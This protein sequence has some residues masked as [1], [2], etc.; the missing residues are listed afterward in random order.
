MAD[1]WAEGSQD[2]HIPHYNL[3]SEQST[4]GSMMLERS[5]LE[6]ARGIVEEADFYRPNHQEIYNALVKLHERDEPVD[7][8][9]LQEEL[10][11]RG[12]LDDCGGTEYLM[13]LVESVATA[14]HV[15]YYAK[16]V[17]KKSTLRL[18][19][20][21]N[22]EHK[23][24]CASPDADP[25]Q[26][27]SWM[28]GKLEELAARDKEEE[29]PWKTLED[30]LCGEVKPVEWIVRGLIPR[31][32]ISMIT[33]DP[34]SMKSWATIA[35]AY[36]VANG[37]PFLGKYTTTKCSVLMHDIENGEQET[38]RRMKR[39]ATG[40]I[41]EGFEF[42]SNA[43]IFVTEK[44]FKLDSASDVA[45]QAAILN[46][47]KIGLV[48][49]DPFIHSLPDGADENSAVDI[50]RFVERVRQLIKLTDCT[51][52]FVHH[53]RKQARDRSSDASQ[54]IRGSS[55]IRGALDSHFFF[56]RLNKGP[57]LCEHD[58]LRQGME[59]QPFGIDIEDEGADATT[60]KWGGESEDIKD[61]SG[62]AVA[63]IERILVDN[64]GPLMKDQIIALCA[65]EKLS[66]G[67]VTRAL[68]DGAKDGTFV[69]T[70]NGRKAL[71]N[72]PMG[73]KRMEVDDD[74]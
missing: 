49:S 30:I 36:S 15:E 57:I 60:I 37:F 59:A 35:V 2:Y 69:R 52:L 54:M 24:R 19:E 26:L 34:S 73:Q 61:K 10:R 39:V 8:I 47:Q 32:G 13:A 3:E 55:A 41:L 1:N 53:A 65:A 64:K 29:L 7:L 20:A 23:G 17:R 12:S 6:T 62:L 63:T 72:L 66:R 38:Q 70:M 68:C 74:D 22:L 46:R 14:A 31:Y 44:P 50:G 67:T 43:P 71:F 11:T 25:K 42:A 18:Y 51:F 56:R 16:I 45:T 4:L 33:G 48:I 5:A 40:M 28:A 21:L 58:K 9:T 27:A